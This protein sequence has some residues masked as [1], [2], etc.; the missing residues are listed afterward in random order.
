MHG[1]RKFCQRGSNFDNFFL[2]EGRD[3]PNTTYHSIGVLLACW[4]G[5]GGV[6]FI[7]LLMDP[8]N[9]CSR[10]TYM[11]DCYCCLLPDCKYN[12]SENGLQNS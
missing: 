5:G 7:Y 12:C 3:D 8:V 1:C 9:A 6:M 4:G 10:E 11:P 2:E